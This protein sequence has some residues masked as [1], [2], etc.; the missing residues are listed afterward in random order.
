MRGLVLISA[1]LVLSVCQQP[2]VPTEELCRNKECGSDV[3]RVQQTCTGSGSSTS[4]QLQAICIPTSQSTF[5]SGGCDFAEPLLERAGDGRLGLATCYTAKPCPS[6]FYCSTKLQDVSSRCCRSDSVSPPT[7]GTCPTVEPAEFFCV[8][9]CLSDADCYQ[10]MKCC[11]RSCARGGTAKTCVM[12]NTNTPL[13]PPTQ[14]PTLPQTVN[15]C[16]TVKCGR[17][18]TCVVSASRQPQ[19]VRDAAVPLPPPHPFG[20]NP[21]PATRLS[22]PTPWGPYARGECSRS[23]QC[24]WPGSTC[25]RGTICC[26]THHCG[27]ICRSPKYY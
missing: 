9:E 1:I 20:N 26:A 25:G 3:C 24:T 23:N 4:C 2:L 22:C 15:A 5:L 7:P 14:P 19:C 13:Q 16:A 27:Q 17:G 6:T 8:E 21:P 10:D 11:T 18:S 12:P